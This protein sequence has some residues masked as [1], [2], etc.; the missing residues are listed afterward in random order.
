MT[1]LELETV[2]DPT[3]FEDIIYLNEDGNEITVNPFKHYKVLQVTREKYED[4]YYMNK[5]LIVIIEE[6][7]L[8]VWISD[9]NIQLG[10]LK[11]S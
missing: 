5:D 6:I 3:Q 10:D 7:K 11:S 1:L 9:I 2:L 8:W 4:V